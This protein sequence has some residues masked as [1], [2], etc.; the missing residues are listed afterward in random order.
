MSDSGT[1]RDLAARL[2]KTEEEEQRRTSQASTRGNLTGHVAI[3]VDAFDVALTVLGRT[4][5]QVLEQ[6]FLERYQ[7]K[8][9]DLV[10]R[11]GPYMSALK[12]M[13][14]E[15]SGVLEKIMLDEIERKSGVRAHTVEEAVNLLKQRDSVQGE[16]GDGGEG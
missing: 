9:E 13:L 16:K 3:M 4:G 12:D 7:L 11:T 14:G 15:S 2:R 8:P 10:L 6:I 1:L 5:A